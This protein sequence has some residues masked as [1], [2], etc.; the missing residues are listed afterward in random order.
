MVNTGKSFLFPVQDVVVL[1]AR[2]W[3]HRSTFSGFVAADLGGAGDC[4][5]A[6]RVPGGA[7]LARTVA[8]RS[9]ASLMK[10]IPI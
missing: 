7:G 3:R 5:A 4:G 2:R 8:G 1:V 9:T 10:W 6:G